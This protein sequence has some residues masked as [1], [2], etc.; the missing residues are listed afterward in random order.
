MNNQHKRDTQNA[1]N[2]QEKLKMQNALGSTDVSNMLVV[3]DNNG[4]SNVNINSDE[5][6]RKK[7]LAKLNITSYIALGLSVLEVGSL[8]FIL[9]MWTTGGINWWMYMYTL[10]FIPTIGLPVPIGLIVACKIIADRRGFRREFGKLPHDAT[11]VAGSFGM[12]VCV[13]PTII[14]IAQLVVSVI[15]LLFVR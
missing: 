10:I 2:V 12:V 9:S 13:L 3:D 6:R 7:A 11:F 8:S 15:R 1:Q 5:D 4:S 14:L